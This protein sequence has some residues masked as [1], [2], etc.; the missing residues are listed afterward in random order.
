MY[1]YLTN[2]HF[3]AAMSSRWRSTGNTHYKV[4]TNT[5]EKAN[6]PYHDLITR[7]LSGGTCRASN[8][9]MNPLFSLRRGPPFLVCP[10]ASRGCPRD[11]ERRR[12]P[13]GVLRTEIPTVTVPDS[14]SLLALPPRTCPLIRPMPSVLL[15]LTLTYPFL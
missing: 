8:S 11:W 9:H 4:D 12:S 15:L 6:S 13:G 5:C 7:N 3:G 1:T 14:H 2:H 10:A